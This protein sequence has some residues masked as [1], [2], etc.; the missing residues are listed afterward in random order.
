MKL[1]VGQLINKFDSL[2][3]QNVGTFNELFTHCRLGRMTQTID[4]IWEFIEYPAWWSVEILTPEEG[5]CRKILLNGKPITHYMPQS[6]SKGQSIKGRFKPIVVD[7]KSFQSTM[8]ACNWYRI[9]IDQFKAK[10]FEKEK[11]IYERRIK[12]DN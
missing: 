5:N 3:V 7:G 4:G 8:S 9:S 12:N 2:E 6:L 10:F 11:G 1:S